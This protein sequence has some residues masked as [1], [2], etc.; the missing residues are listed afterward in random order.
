MFKEKLYKQ[1]YLYNLLWSIEIDSL[2]E[3][4]LLH[5]A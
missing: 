4:L 3:N 5:A 2:P 1:I